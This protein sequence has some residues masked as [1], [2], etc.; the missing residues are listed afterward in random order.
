MSRGVWLAAL[1]LAGCSGAGPGI[2]PVQNAT[3]SSAPELLAV[4][5]GAR[6]DAGQGALASNSAL[7]R[8]AI[9]HAQDMAEKGYFD[10]VA[11]DGS[12]PLRRMRAAGYE[13]CYA[14]ENI[15]KGQRD[16]DQVLRAWLGSEGHRR[17][18]LSPDPKAAGTARG[19]GDIWVMTYARAC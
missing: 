1:L 5:N 17:N 7:D 6:R 10:H 19:T 14:A 9:A 18:L 2:A 8:A 11:P 4:V 13:A 12:T 16:A 15:A 3:A